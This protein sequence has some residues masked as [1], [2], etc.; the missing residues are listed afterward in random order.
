MV[1]Y[2]NTILLGLALAGQMASAA[3]TADGSWTGNDFYDA[4]NKIGVANG[5]PYSNDALIQRRLVAS[6]SKDTDMADYM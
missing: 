5:I 1:K 6:L 2:N 3:I 4:A